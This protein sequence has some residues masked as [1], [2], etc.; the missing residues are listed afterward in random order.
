[1]FQSPRE[2]KETLLHEMI[3]G[4]EKLLFPN[5]QQ[6]LVLFLYEKFQKRR[7]WRK[8]GSSMGVVNFRRPLKVNMDEETFTF[9]LNEN[10]PF[11]IT[12][13]G[14]L[15]HGDDCVEDLRRWETIDKDETFIHEVWLPALCH[16]H[17]T[18]YLR[19]AFEK[20]YPD[21]DFESEFDY[22]TPGVIKRIR[23]SEFSD[24]E[25]DARKLKLERLK[26]EIDKLGYRLVFEKKGG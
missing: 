7:N 3:H 6:I 19:F 23:E 18:D 16:Y 13:K 17:T 26:E 9:S 11:K 2:I 20:K 25:E 21:K 10:L 4:Y 24:L 8:E 15:I 1:L 12:S 22:H 5:Y 14:K